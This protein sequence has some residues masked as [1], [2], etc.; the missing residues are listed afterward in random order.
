MTAIAAALWSSTAVAQET[1]TRVITAGD[2]FR[3]ATRWEKASALMG[4]KV[5]NNANENLGK[6]EDIVIDSNS[7]RILYG[8]LSFGGFLGMGDK[9]FAIPWS[10]LQL[11]SGDQATVLN[12]DKDRLKNA[13]GFDKKNWPNFA[14]EQFATATYKHYEVT[15]YWQARETRMV[16]EK[17]DD[18]AVTVYRER[19]YQPAKGWQKTSDL[20]GKNVRNRQNED[21]GEIND[22][23]IDPESGRVLY[24]ILKFKGKYFSIPWPAVSPTSDNKYINLDISKDMLKDE[25]G[26]DKDRWPNFA[27][28]RW[29]TE[30]YN[31][32]HVKP[33]W[34]TTTKYEEKVK[35]GKVKIKETRERH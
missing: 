30:T 32:Y 2:D 7:G 34:T 29:A 17:S 15:P 4:R 18:G 11:N 5:I 26:F 28:E 8:V 23:A 31:Y 13:P 27:D 1:R 20:I 33:Y 10:S 14:D 22:L 19:W 3:M 35:D 9:L 12:V 24:A 21:I 6:I 25:V 16:S